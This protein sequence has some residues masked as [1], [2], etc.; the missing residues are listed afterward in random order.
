MPSYGVANESGAYENH[1]ADS[2]AETPLL[3]H[4][5]DDES[6]SKPVREGKAG[7]TSSIGNLANTILGTGMLATPMASKL[8][9]LK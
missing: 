3:G 1:A 2:T 4:T 6:L 9:D 8:S 7:L 5:G